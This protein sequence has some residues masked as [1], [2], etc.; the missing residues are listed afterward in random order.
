MPDEVI[1]GIEVGIA[2]FA[3]FLIIILC[4]CKVSGECSRE[5]EQEETTRKLQG[6]EYLLDDENRNFNIQDELG[7][8]DEFVKKE[9]NDEIHNSDR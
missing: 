9:G 6:K 4:A 3:V 7:Y 1:F 5:E 8:N 2:I